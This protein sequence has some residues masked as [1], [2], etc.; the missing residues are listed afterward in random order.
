MYSYRKEDI[1]EWPVMLCVTQKH[2]WAEMSQ[3]FM[4]GRGRR[5]V[6]M[7]WKP[8]DRWTL[9]PEGC[10]GRTEGNRPTTGWK[11]YLP[12][13]VSF[14]PTHSATESWPCMWGLVMRNEDKDRWLLCELWMA[15]DQSVV[16]SVR[17]FIQ[18]SP[19]KSTAVE[20]G[21]GVHSCDCGTWKSKSGELSQV[22]GQC[23]LTTQ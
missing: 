17:W 21:V 8:C 11:S 18:W 5:P 20:P 14:C 16:I 13:F 9:F 7:V 6:W 3:V 2:S 4:E 22:W 12:M 10:L 15:G 1:E 19:L 23:G